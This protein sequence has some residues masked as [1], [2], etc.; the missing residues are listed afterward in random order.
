M[1]NYKNGDRVICI[2]NGYTCSGGKEHHYKIGDIGTYLNPKHGSSNV[3]WDNGQFNYLYENV[4]NEM[5]LYTG[6]EVSKAPDKKIEGTG[7]GFE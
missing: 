2:K 5:K 3:R 6:P 4:D 1:A 7:W